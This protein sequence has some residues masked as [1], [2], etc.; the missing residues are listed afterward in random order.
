MSL[1][2]NLPWLQHPWVSLGHSSS[3]APPRRP[4][5]FPSPAVTTQGLPKT[6]GKG[7]GQFLSLV[8][9]TEIGYCDHLPSSGVPRDPHSTITALEDLAERFH[10][11]SCG[12]DQQQ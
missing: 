12:T 8:A 2:L 9:K 4:A 11:V 5:T 10:A 3:G 1:V 7:K 6:L